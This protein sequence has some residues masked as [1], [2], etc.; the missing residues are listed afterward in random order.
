MESKTTN[1]DQFWEFIK[2]LDKQLKSRLV[3]ITYERRIVVMFDNSSIH[4]TK[5]KVIGKEIRMGCIYNSTIF[6]RTK[7]NRAHFWDTKVEDV[8]GTLMQRQ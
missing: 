6:T 8:K 2:L 1:E 7:P 4:N 5:N 3:K